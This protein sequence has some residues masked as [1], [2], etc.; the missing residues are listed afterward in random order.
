M[1]VLIVPLL[2]LLATAQSGVYFYLIKIE[3]RLTKVEI[4]AD[5]FYNSSCCDDKNKEVIT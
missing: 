4:L 1:D 5:R 2:L 3:R